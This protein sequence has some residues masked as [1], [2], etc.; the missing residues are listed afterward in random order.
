MRL[1][2]QFNHTVPVDADRQLNDRSADPIRVDGRCDARL[3]RSALH[4]IVDE[5]HYS[6]YELD[7]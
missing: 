5:G 2:N 3:P 4:H 6:I 7:A 1:R